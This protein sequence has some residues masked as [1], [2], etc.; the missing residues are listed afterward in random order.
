MAETTFTEI[1]LCH[2]IEKTLEKVITP[3]TSPEVRKTL[4]EFGMR[5]LDE[6]ALPGRERNE[7]MKREVEERLSRL[8][9][10]LSAGGP[11]AE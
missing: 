8:R 6:A 2:L 7:Q 1:Q 11:A 3:D 10:R 4:C 5:L 9:A